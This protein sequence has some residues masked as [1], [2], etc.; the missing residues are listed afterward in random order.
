MFY[1]KVYIICLNTA[2]LS[3]MANSNPVFSS[4]PNVV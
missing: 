4:C 2:G 3:V 1:K